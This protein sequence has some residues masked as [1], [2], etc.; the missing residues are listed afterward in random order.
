MRRDLLHPYT[1]SRE[2]ASELHVQHLTSH[3]HPDVEA[4]W[5]SAS[6]GR[7]VQFVHVLISWTC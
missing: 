2:L 3:R 6:R 5:L 4:M 1:G 7:S